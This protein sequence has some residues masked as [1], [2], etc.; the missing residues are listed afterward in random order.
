MYKLF[1]SLFIGSSLSFAQMVNGIAITVNDE[2]ITLY[3]IDRTMAVN[4]VGKNEAVSYLIDKVLYD[5]LV[6][7]N[8]ISADIF[9]INDY[10]EKLANANGMDVYTFKSI[11]KQKYSDYEVFENEAKNTVIRQKLV[12]KI[13]KGQ[14]TIATQEDMELY[15]EKNKNQF[16]TAKNF[17]VIQ[18][19]SKNKASL[20]ATIKNPLLIAEDVEKNTISLDSEKLQTQMQYLL[21]ETQENSFTP[22]FTA[23]KQ[24]VTLFIQKK[25]GSTPLAFESVKAKIFNDIMSLREKMYLKDYFEKQKLTA[26]IKIVR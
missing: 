12:Q 3:D 18:Y 16:L 10:I 17:D 13:V 7:E 14:L 9:D 11:V 15:Y 8:N 1:L 25:T 22:I 24:Y 5:Q 6:Q 21:N 19:S 4:K 23:N 2:P 20:I 26:D